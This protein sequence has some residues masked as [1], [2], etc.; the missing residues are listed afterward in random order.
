MYFN[1]KWYFNRKAFSKRAHSI[2]VLISKNNIV[3][4]YAVKAAASL[5]CRVSFKNMQMEF[6]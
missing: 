4:S 6:Q 3:Q 5:V 2:K 1:E